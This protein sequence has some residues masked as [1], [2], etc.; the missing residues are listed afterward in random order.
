MLCF[1][2]LVDK[3][4]T[5]GEKQLFEKRDKVVAELS[6]LKQRADEFSD[7]GEL[8]MVQQYVLDVRAVQKRLSEAQEQIAWIH[9]EENLYRFEITQF[10]EVDEI[11]YM[12]DPFMKLFQLISKWQRLEKK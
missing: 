6:K 7:Y 11:A 4:K 10:P 3:M 8:D 5:N 2:Q 9:K 1:C 12:I